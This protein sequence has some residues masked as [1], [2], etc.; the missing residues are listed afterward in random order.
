M[1]NILIK[2]ICELKGNICLSSYFFL[3]S[4]SDIYFSSISYWISAPLISI[5]SQSGSVGILAM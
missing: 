2:L 5:G 3:F 4:A 1:I